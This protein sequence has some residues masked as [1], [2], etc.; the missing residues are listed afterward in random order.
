M[1]V[2]WSNP[3]RLLVKS[4][5]DNEE[6]TI[7]GGLVSRRGSSKHTSDLRGLFWQGEGREGPPRG[8][9]SSSSLNLSSGGEEKRAIRQE[10]QS[11]S[12]EFNRLQQL[13]VLLMSHVEYF[14]S[15]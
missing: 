12:G 4:H 1:N 13:S 2:S 9:R 14:N 6:R 3:A 10:S 5:P 15:I 8:R 11:D 7:K